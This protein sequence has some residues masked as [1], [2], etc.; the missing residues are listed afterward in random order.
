[1][2]SEVRT[3]MFS[4]VKVSSLHLHKYR[5]CLGGVTCRA[6]WLVVPESRA[7][8]RFDL[9][10]GA[11]VKSEVR[12]QMFSNVKVRFSPSLSLIPRP[13]SGP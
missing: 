8:L 11:A 3:Q 12:T 2:K 9:G 4:N 5:A 7:A 1:V 6:C 13:D 10:R